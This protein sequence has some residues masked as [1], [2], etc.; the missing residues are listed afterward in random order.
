MFGKQDFTPFPYPRTWQ[1]WLA[2]LGGLGCRLSSPGLWSVL[3]GFVVFSLA[4]LSPELFGALWIFGAY[5]VWSY[6][7]K[8]GPQAESTVIL[9]LFFG[10]WIAMRG[11][12]PGTALGGV[13]LFRVFTLLR[14]FPLH[15][16]YSRWCGL[17]RML[18]SALGGIC[19]AVILRGLLWLFFEN[20]MMSLYRF[21]G[22]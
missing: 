4:P 20:G 6:V 21:F 2:T 13:L 18:A 12:P 1:G 8:G 9:D 3:L 14:P 5:A 10:T 17:G 7:R 11:N 16:L 22:G 15:A 19:A